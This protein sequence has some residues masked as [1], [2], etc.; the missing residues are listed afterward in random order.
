VGDDGV[1]FV[2][3]PLTMKVLAAKVQAALDRR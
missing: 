1:R 2:Q 3:K